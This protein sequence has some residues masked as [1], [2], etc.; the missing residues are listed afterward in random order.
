MVG[1][2]HIIFQGFMV[3]LSLTKLILFV[4]KQIKTITIGPL[5]IWPTRSNMFVTHFFLL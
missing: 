4:T 2:N 3:L 1:T 5:I